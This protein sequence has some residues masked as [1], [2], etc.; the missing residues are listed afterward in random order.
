MTL[1]S[2]GESLL[3]VKQPHNPCSDVQIFTTPE[4]NQTTRGHSAWKPHAVTWV[5]IIRCCLC[6]KEVKNLFLNWRILELKIWRLCPKQTSVFTIFS[7]QYLHLIQVSETQSYYKALKH[8]TDEL[9]TEITS[10]L[11]WIHVR[12]YQ[13]ISLQSAGLCCSTSGSL[14]QVLPSPSK[15]LIPNQQGVDI[16]PR[17]SVRIPVTNLRGL[18][19]MQLTRFAFSKMS[20]IRGSFLTDWI[21]AATSLIETRE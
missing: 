3:N 18:T 17:P 21:F 12:D 8:M 16:L 13:W 14:E 1:P 7:K 19:F 15:V 5:S 9:K 4:I 10:C 2:R 20:V 6:L 11:V